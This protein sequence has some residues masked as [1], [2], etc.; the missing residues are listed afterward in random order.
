M[1]GVD[2][3]VIAA[4]SAASAYIGFDIGFRRM[5]W[6][7]LDIVLQEIEANELRKQGVEGPEAQ[8]SLRLIRMDRLQRPTAFLLRGKQDDAR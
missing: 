2:V 8:R 5:S 4:T 6:R 3:L 7:V 1:T